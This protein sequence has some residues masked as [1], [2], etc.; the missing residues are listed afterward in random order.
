[1]EF[2]VSWILS[3]S[4]PAA[5]E[6]RGVQ[7]RRPVVR[8]LCRV[9]ACLPWAALAAAELPAPAAGDGLSVEPGLGIR[10]EKNLF[11]L[12]PGDPAAAHSERVFIPYVRLRYER[13]WSLQSLFID[14]TLDEHRYRDHP[15]LDHQG[16]RY[17]AAWRWAITPHLSGSLAAEGEKALTSFADFRG[18][19]DGNLQSRQT[20]RLSLDW[21]MGGGM[22]ALAGVAATRL[23]NSRAFTEVAT[24]RLTQGEFGLRYV[25]TAGSEFTLMR[26]DGEGNYPD[27]SVDPVNG[28]DE[29]FRRRDTEFSLAWPLSA[30]SQL[31]LNLGRVAQSYPNVPARNFSGSQWRADYLW[32]PAASLTLQFS[33]RRELGEWQDRTA[34]YVQSDSYTF[35]P[36]WA[37]SEKLRFRAGVM[38]QTRHYLGALDAVPQARRDRLRGV[39]YGLAWTPRSALTLG[40]TART[41][42]RASS[43]DAVAAL[44]DYSARSLALDVRLHF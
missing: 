3:F 21:W 22:H 5:P 9:L 10:Q 32:S 18:G 11:R 23:R 13:G 30:K 26:R 40:L 4:A 20:E 7:A 1:M 43:P 14:A 2:M 8:G 33:A 6:R 28:F 44:R 36:V 42:S 37:W 29:R 38:R 15:Q 16:R 34:S 25:S 24:S 12:P 35:A 17:V 19:K 31:K 39:E 41:E 27:R